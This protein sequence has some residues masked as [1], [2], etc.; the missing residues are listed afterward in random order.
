MLLMAIRLFI[1]KPEIPIEENVQYYS[2]VSEGNYIEC[3]GRFTGQCSMCPSF[4][5][6]KVKFGTALFD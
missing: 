6:K 4:F 1:R 5:S 2:D 3:L